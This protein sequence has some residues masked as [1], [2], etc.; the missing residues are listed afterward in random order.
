MCKINIWSCLSYCLSHTSFG[1]LHFQE[2][3]HVA[4]SG[5]CTNTRADTLT[6]ARTITLCAH[7]HTWQKSLSLVTSLSVTHTHTHTH[8]HQHHLLHWWYFCSTTAPSHFLLL[9]RMLPP[10]SVS[11]TSSS[12]P[13]SLQASPQAPHSNLLPNWC[14]LTASLSPSDAVHNQP[15]AQ[16]P[17]P[18]FTECDRRTASW[19]DSTTRRIKKIPATQVCMEIGLTCLGMVHCPC[20]DTDRC[21]WKWSRF[22]F[23]LLFFS[24]LLL[25]PPV[26]RF[27]FFTKRWVS[28]SLCRYPRS[29]SLLSFYRP[30]SLCLT[31][32]LAFSSLH[33]N[34]LREMAVVQQRR[35]WQ[36]CACVWLRARVCVYVCEGEVEW[37]SVN[38]CVCERERVGRTLQRYEPWETVHAGA[39]MLSTQLRMKHKFCPW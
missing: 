35:S 14:Y 21:S 6:Q 22:L 39:G 26:P 36:H 4:D 7:L 37:E 2:V 11:S 3:I 1:A 32:A 28:P 20:C 10:P 16:P 27:L 19:L 15:S 30:P 18:A 9:P 13:T 12:Y 33:W 8:T 23:P 34:L 31:L 5:T 38:V 29:Y 17:S 25:P 24:S